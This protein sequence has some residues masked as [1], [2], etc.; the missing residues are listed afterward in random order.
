[1]ANK[2]LYGHWL[3]EFAFRSWEIWLRTMIA[4]FKGG[5]Q[6]GNRVDSRE[7]VENKLGEGYNKNSDQEKC[8]DLEDHQNSTSFSGFA[9]FSQGTDIW[10][11]HD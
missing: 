11:V 5:L 9:P 6:R 3:G 2:G 10:T 1:M 4:H 7:I 8:S